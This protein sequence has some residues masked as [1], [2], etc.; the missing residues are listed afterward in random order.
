MARLYAILFN[1]LSLKTGVEPMGFESSQTGPSY[2]IFGVL[3]ALQRRTFR[4][5]RLDCKKIVSYLYKEN[6]DNSVHISVHKK[7]RHF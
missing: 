7:N 5:R 3:K 2:H 1:L 6:C 4:P